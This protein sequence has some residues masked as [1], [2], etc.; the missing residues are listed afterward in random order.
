MLLVLAAQARPDA[1]IR[2]GCETVPACIARVREVADRSEGITDSEQDVAKWLQSL[3][4]ESI[5]AVMDLLKD[6]DDHVREMAGYV[7]RDMPGLRPEHL[8]P[9]ERAVEVGDGW[10]PPAIASIGTPDAIRF[11][12]GELKKKPETHTQLTYAFERLGPAAI[13]EL[14][15]L[16]RCGSSCDESLLRVVEFILSETRDGA[17]EAVDPLLSIATEEGGTLI[18]RRGALR[19]LAALG[20]TAR[21]AVKT[22]LEMTRRKPVDLQSEARRALLAIGGSGTREA[23]EASLDGAED[24]R[25]VLRDLAALGDGGRE[26]GSRVE[27]LL[28]SSEPD[29]RVAAARALGFIRYREATPSLVAALDDPD[30]WRVAYVAAE[31][32]GHFARSKDATHYG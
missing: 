20:V 23:L 26:A 18:A 9:L 21:P 25:L 30:D 31:A 7:L 27:K 32:L 17:A 2:A 1:T 14:L 24:Q 6:P 19:A 16:F 13:P 4:P 10:L 29:V 12:V 11:L 15:E 5:P 22:L 3:S 28:S 8:G